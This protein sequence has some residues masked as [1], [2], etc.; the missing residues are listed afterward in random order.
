MKDYMSYLKFD[1]WDINYQFPARSSNSCCSFYVLNDVANFFQFLKELRT[2]LDAS[3]GSGK[4]LIIIAIH[5]EPYSNSLNPLGNLSGFAEYVDYFNPM[6]YDVKGV[7]IDTTG[8]KAPLDYQGEI[9]RLF[10][11]ETSIEAWIRAGIPANK[12]NGGLAFYG[13]AETALVDMSNS[14]N[15][16]QPRSLTIPRGNSD[17]MQEE[18]P[19][20]HGPKVFSGIWKYFD[21]RSQGVVNMTNTATVPWIRRYDNPASMPWLFKK[22]TKTFVSYEDTTSISA[23]A[24]HAAQKGLM[25]V[26]VSS[27]TSDY[28]NNLIGA[29]V[30]ALNA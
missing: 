28:N 8:P 9:A 11:F 7:P 2:D 3:F 27:P 24:K 5:Y 12:I 17:E 13:H 10:S 14:S 18:D 29:A 6:I 23:K 22:D 21:L 4:R 1:G 26:M 19:V 25:G 20:C 15:M 30:S 16:Y